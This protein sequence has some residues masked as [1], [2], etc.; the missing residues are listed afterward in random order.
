MGREVGRLRY[1][2]DVTVIMVKSRTLS[3]FPHTC[4]MALASWEV[5]SEAELF[6]REY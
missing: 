4:W 3:F 5:V 6:E 2:G 1:F